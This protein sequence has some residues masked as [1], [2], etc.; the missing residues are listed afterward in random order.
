MKLLVTGNSGFIG[1]NLTHSLL[2]HGHNVIGFDKNSNNI[3]HENY[4][5]VQGNILNQTEVS[6]SMSGDINCLIH[7]A[8]E[9][10]DYGIAEAEYFS[11]VQNNPSR[12]LVSGLL[13]CDGPVAERL[14]DG[15]ER[16]L[17]L[18]GIGAIPCAIR[19]RRHSRR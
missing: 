17:V 7:L 15:R 18:R 12:N 19:Y 14:V 5:F 11:A 3:Q 10:K 2:K 16:G 9:H 1:L 6:A 8:A 4:R 13:R